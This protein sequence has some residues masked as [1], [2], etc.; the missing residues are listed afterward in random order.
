MALSCLMHQLE[1][2]LRKTSET[3]PQP[4]SLVLF[5]TM[6][7]AKALPTM[8]WCLGSLARILGLLQANNSSG[9]CEW[10]NTY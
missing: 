6:L 3:Q 10:F 5:S 2:W 7:Q 8:S 1:V 9:F 4:T